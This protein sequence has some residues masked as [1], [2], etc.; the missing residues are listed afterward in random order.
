MLIAGAVTCSTCLAII[1]PQLALQNMFGGTLD[2]A[3]AEVVV[4]SWGALITLVGA[5]LIYASNRPLH[6]SLVL[7][8]A[9]ISKLVFVGLIISFGKQFLGHA[10][11]I[12]S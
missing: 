10:W 3:L 7:V 2:G 5:M 9:T 4:R 1:N 8:V 6:R 11:R 12:G